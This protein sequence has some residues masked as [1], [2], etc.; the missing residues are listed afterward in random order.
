M[1]FHHTAFL[2]RIAILVLRITFESIIFSSSKLFTRALNIAFSKESFS[3]IQRKSPI[4]LLCLHGGKRFYQN[5]KDTIC[6]VN[7]T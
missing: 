6:I 3:I 7:I 1:L 4:T 5:F 2:L